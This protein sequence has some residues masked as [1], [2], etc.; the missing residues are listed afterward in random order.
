MPDEPTSPGI[1]SVLDR[2][3]A[4][5]LSREQFESEVT[6][7]VY[8]GLHRY[9]EI[10]DGYQHCDLATRVLALDSLSDEDLRALLRSPPAEIIN[11]HPSHIK[12]IELFSL[13]LSGEAI[14]CEGGDPLNPNVGAYL[15][16]PPGS[17]K[18]HVMA[19]Y[20]RQ[21]KE[22]LDDKLEHVKRLMGDVIGTAIRQVQ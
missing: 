5:L 15:Y 12:A 21:V 8:S 6:N 10:P 19:A 9:C 11:P 22:L 7:Q 2:I 18:T 4:G 3:E 1:P 14:V 20:G 17:G 13:L 16:G